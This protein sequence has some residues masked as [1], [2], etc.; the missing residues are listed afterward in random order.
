M[1][2]RSVVVWLAAA[3]GAMA[4]GCAEAVIRK[5]PNRGDY[6]RWTDA[7]QRR[8]DSMCG[9]RYYLQRPYVVVNRPFPVRSHTYLVDAHVS[10]DGQRVRIIGGE[11]KK[12]AEG[13]LHAGFSG[14]AQEFESESVWRA[15]PSAPSPKASGPQ[16]PQT[17]PRAQGGA[18]PV[19]EGGS[20]PQP[21]PSGETGA[22]QGA[23]PGSPFVNGT[24]KPDDQETDEDSGLPP[25]TPAAG[26]SAPPTTIEPPGADTPAEER[27]A[28][29]RTGV[30]DFRISTDLKGMPLQDVND[31]I[32]LVYLPDFEEQYVIDP[33]ANLGSLDLTLTQG[34][35]GILMAMGVQV[36]NS[37]ITRPLVD[38]YADLVKSGLAALKGAMGHPQAQSGQLVVQPGA[39]H[40]AEV[41]P[42]S[43]ITL[44]VHVVSMATPG[45]YPILK[46]N[47]L[48]DNRNCKRE[49]GRCALCCGQRVPCA[50]CCSL[51]A[52]GGDVV[53]V[54][55]VEPK[56]PFTRVAYGVHSILIVEHLVSQGTNGASSALSALFRSSGAPKAQSQSIKMATSADHRE[57]LRAELNNL[58]ATCA[59]ARYT[60]TAIDV[61]EPATAARLD[62]VVVL[63]LRFQRVV[64]GQP[65]SIHAVLR[66]Q[67]EGAVRCCL[68]KSG[69]F[70]PTV[71]LAVVAE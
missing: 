15:A 5:V 23:A 1:N 2:S 29:T 13:L 38:A 61:A 10:A 3:L 21:P 30:T 53:H 22:G 55:L 60:V 48:L 36:D 39:D 54:D 14:A 11:A 20:Q 25:A 6:E 27:K 56:H 19:E 32:S 44:R 35:G 66:A 17:G 34:P 45:L 50:T 8:V 67:D 16:D 37:A 28:D 33:K 70:A 40:R 69:R 7:D 71:R 64:G 43:I 63:S 65:T 57:A 26:P 12:L 59:C 31:Y 24:E 18:I 62:E 68:L 42:G 58:L 47:E 51:V 41:T 46:A 4:A 49:V 9:H 52:D